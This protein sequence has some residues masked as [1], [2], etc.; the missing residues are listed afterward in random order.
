MCFGVAALRVVVLGAVERVGV[1]V[2]GA[3]VL[4]AAAERAGVTVFG[5]VVLGAVVERVGVEAFGAT[6]AA[7]RVVAVAL[8]V[9]VERL[10][11]LG[12]GEL[13]TTRLSTI[14]GLLTAGLPVCIPKSYAPNSSGL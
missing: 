5:A 9:V 6:G 13:L 4:G 7:L 8:R 14:A 2:F 10:C 11:V 12:V 1:V 3:V